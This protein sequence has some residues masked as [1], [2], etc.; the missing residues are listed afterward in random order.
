MGAG[1]VGRQ[2]TVR[3]WRLTRGEGGVREMSPK[4]F[5][6]MSKTEFDAVR[7]SQAEWHFGGRGNYYWHVWHKLV[8]LRRV[9]GAEKTQGPAELCAAL[10]GSGTTL[11]LIKSD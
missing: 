9:A 10:Y 7:E 2:R 11:C 6:M 8:V 3:A 5:E 1:K 4:L